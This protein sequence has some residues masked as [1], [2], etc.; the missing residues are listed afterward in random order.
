MRDPCA[1]VYSKPK[2]C[3]S[4]VAPFGVEGSS[5]SARSDAHFAIQ[6]KRLNKSGNPV[7]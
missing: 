5:D 2:Q 6:T 3:H 4:G 7:S 1:R